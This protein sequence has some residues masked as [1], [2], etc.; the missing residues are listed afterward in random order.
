MH[1]NSAIS[2]MFADGALHQM[3]RNEYH[4]HPEIHNITIS[5]PDIW[6]LNIN[7]HDFWKTGAAL[8]LL[9]SRVLRQRRYTPHVSQGFYDLWCLQLFSNNSSFTGRWLDMTC[10]DAMVPNICI[11]DSWQSWTHTFDIRGW[12]RVIEI[13]IHHNGGGRQLWVYW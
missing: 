3:S 4:E 10:Q 13:D 9:A 6:V 2:T 8:K 1:V 12:Q 5:S 11:N 7:E